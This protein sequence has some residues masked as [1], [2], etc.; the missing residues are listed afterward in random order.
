[1][2]IKDIYFVCNITTTRDSMRY[3]RKTFGIKWTRLSNAFTGQETLVGGLGRGYHSHQTKEEHS[4]EEGIMYCPSNRVSERRVGLGGPGF[5]QIGSYR[6]GGK[7]PE[8]FCLCFS[9]GMGPMGGWG[10]RT[11]QR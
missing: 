7:D 3:P 5:F 10:H 1:M 2:S 4:S 9:P 6:G 11:V 8:G